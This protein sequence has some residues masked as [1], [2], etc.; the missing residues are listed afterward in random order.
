[1]FFEQFWVRF[2]INKIK[3]TL[4]VAY[5]PPGFNNILGFYNSFEGVICN[6]LADW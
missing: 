5:C 2:T 4:G 3:F 6:L 1:M